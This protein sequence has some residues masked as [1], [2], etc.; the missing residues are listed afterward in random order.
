MLSEQRLTAQQAVRA[1]LYA[2]L[3]Q[4]DDA[5]ATFDAARALGALEPAPPRRA[6]AGYLEA[7]ALQR[8]PERALQVLG[9]R[10]EAGGRP[11]AATYAALLRAAAT[12]PQSARS[13]PHSRSASSRSC[14]SRGCAST[15]TPSGPAAPTA[16]CQSV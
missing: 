14:S 9:D 7:L 1:A 10:R 6:F 5:V 2:R 12:A 3:L 13:T 11:A 15:T 16:C 8:L 4:G